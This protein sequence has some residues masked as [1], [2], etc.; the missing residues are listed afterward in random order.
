MATSSEDGGKV[1][2]DVKLALVN[3][4]KD[5]EEVDI[6]RKVLT[7]LEKLEEDLEEQGYE[8]DSEVAKA[9]KKLLEAIDLVEVNEPDAVLDEDAENDEVEEVGEK[10]PELNDDDEEEEL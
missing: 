4:V 5:W 3:Y 10:E 6:S 2:A 7:L 8:R 9:H 1:V